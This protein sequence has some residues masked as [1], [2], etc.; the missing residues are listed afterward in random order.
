MLGVVLLHPIVKPEAEAQ[1]EPVQQILRCFILASVL[2]PQLQLGGPVRLNDLRQH[3]V[4]VQLGVK[5]RT[6]CSVRHRL[7]G[8][9]LLPTEQRP[10]SFRAAR[11]SFAVVPGH[12]YSVL[13]EVNLRENTPHEIL[14]SKRL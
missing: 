12:L 2:V 7:P 13:R 9:R 6:L 14:H 11:L 5:L 10:Q 8:Y 4:S 3:E 1:V